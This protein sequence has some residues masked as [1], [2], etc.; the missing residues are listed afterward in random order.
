VGRSPVLGRRAEKYMVEEKN[1]IAVCASA[2]RPREW[3]VRGTGHTALVGERLESSTA[4]AA[5][6]RMF[7]YTIHSRGEWNAGK[8]KI[9]KQ[10]T[11]GRAV[12]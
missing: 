7:V 3:R 6:A 9:T 4:A 8:K 5:A 10:G 11:K 12:E 1:V 2:G